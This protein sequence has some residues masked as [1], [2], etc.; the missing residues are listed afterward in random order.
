MAGDRD[1]RN[2]GK[3]AETGITAHI[4]CRAGTGGNSSAVRV[5]YWGNIRAD[6]PLPLGEGPGV[7]VLEAGC[8]GLLAF[9]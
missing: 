2:G 3:E 9:G 1:C 4:N 8:A 7:R 5:H 6:P